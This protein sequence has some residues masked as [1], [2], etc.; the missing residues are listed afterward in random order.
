MTS[1]LC[2]L[3]LA[4]SLLLPACYD[5]HGLE[6]RLDA[7]GPIDVDAA[8]RPDVW[9]P[10]TS[11]AGP[12]ADVPSLCPLVRAD[13]SCLESNAIVAG[14]PFELPFQ[15]DACA[16][17]PE[18]SCSVSVDEASRTL[19]LSTGLCL[20]RCDCD[21]CNTPR[22]TCTVP[23]ISEAALGQWTVEVNGT[24]AFRIGVV[25][26]DSPIE[27]PLR[28]CSTYAEIDDCGGASPDF[29]MG[30]IRG[31]VCVEAVAHADRTTLR[32]TDH[33]WGCGRI[34]SAC[35]VS[36]FER[37]TADLPPGYDIQL[38]AGAYDTAC[39][40]DC[41]AVCTPHTRECDIPALDP[42]AFNRVMIDG[43]FVAAFGGGAPMT[44]CATDGP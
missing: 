34:D 24:A 44:V 39:D 37:L 43:E 10:P 7:G 13:A 8:P 38:H 25:P 3:V 29:T 31:D 4:F 22:G 27:P 33:C 9:M 40:V 32:L 41:P 28:A 5:M 35:E 30:P 18:T 11:D 26:G 15:Y 23:P 17:C 42:A 21:A 2:H 36:V 20:D 14:R 1:R 19:R 12:V 6:G 16:C